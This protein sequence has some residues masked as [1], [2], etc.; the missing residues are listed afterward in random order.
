[1][2][3]LDVVI[4]LIVV[5]SAVIGLVRGF[6]KGS[7]A[8]ITWVAAIWLAV[9][10][11]RNLATWLPQSLEGARFA[12]GGIDF[13]ISNMRIGIAFIL[14]I[15]GALIAGATVNLLLSK[16]TKAQVLR[17]ADRFLGLIFGAAR[18][19]AIVLILV[20]AAGLT[21]APQTQWW[22]TATLMPPFEQGAIWAL[23][24]L[25]RDLAQHFSFAGKV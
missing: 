21:K 18:G 12:L 13:E 20:L 25:P 7:V 23:D 8:L 3:W 15:I 4:I 14:L 2:S 24:L 22:R 17:G 16:V 11:S 6:I 9:V 10:F 5:I 1:M 19:L